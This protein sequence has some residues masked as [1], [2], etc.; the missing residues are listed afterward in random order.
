MKTFAIDPSLATIIAGHVIIT[1]P[2]VILIVGARL[3]ELRPRGR[4]GGAR[5]GDY[6]ADGPATDHA[7]ADRAVDPRCDGDLVRD[8]LRRGPDHQL[9]VGHAPDPAALRAFPHA[10]NDRPVGQCG[11]DDPA[12]RALG[13]RPRLPA[14]ATPPC[15]RT[16]RGPD[17]RHRRGGIERPRE[18]EQYSIA[19]VSKRF[20]SV[21]ALETLDLE[22]P[23]GIVL[24]PPRAERLREDDP[25]AHH[26]RARGAR[27]GKG[28]RRRHRYHESAHG[29]H[30]RSTWCSKTTP[31]S[32]T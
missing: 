31:C 11:R 12:R 20:G 25:A 26:R 30:G 21:A 16:G 8:L 15:A 5:S 19:G 1:T 28:A 24:Q 6:P 3:P 17:R 14:C 9:H 18:A 2:F 13:G 22:I 27:R 29:A 10:S 23:A 7:P 32:R 4:A